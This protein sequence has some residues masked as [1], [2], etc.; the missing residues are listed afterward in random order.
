MQKFALAAIATV[1][2]A[3]PVMA[4][5][6][7][8]GDAPRA[9]WMSEDAVKAKAAGLGY[10]V[11]SVKAEKGCYEVY[12]IDARG[13]KAEVLFNPVTGEQVGSEMDD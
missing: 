3:S 10:Q 2:I 4:T 11:R 1:L 5:E 13:M 7:S 9:Q 8:C 6:M 12:A